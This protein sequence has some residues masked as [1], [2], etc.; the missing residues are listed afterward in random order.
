MVLVPVKKCPRVIGPAGSPGDENRTHSQVFS[1]LRKQSDGVL[2]TPGQ[3]FVGQHVAERVS[4]KKSLKQAGN[5]F[6]LTNPNCILRFLRTTME[7]A[8]SDENP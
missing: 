1:N 3:R 5:S 7:S 6:I 8:A 4:Q 2:V